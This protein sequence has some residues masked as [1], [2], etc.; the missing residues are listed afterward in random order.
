M[1]LRHRYSLHQA[2]ATFSVVRA[3]SAKFGL[4][5]GNVKF[6]YAECIMNKYACNYLCCFTGNVS[7]SNKNILMIIGST[8]KKSEIYN[9]G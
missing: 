4:H 9:L 2:C 7:L 6:Q 1:L 5:A 3:T 8:Y